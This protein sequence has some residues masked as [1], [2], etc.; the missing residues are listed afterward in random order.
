MNMS[1]E[2]IL[3]ILLVGIIVSDHVATQSQNH[4]TDAGSVVSSL[5]ERN[6]TN[7][8]ERFRNEFLAQTPVSSREVAFANPQAM[9]ATQLPPIELIARALDR[10]MPRRPL[11]HAKKRMPQL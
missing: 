4:I 11:P 8:P 7:Q 9:A 3:V 6:H 1:T 2:S 5:G 10:V